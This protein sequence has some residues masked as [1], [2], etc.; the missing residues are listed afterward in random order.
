MQHR[1]V[2]PRRARTRHWAG[3]AVLAAVTAAFAMG[4]AAPTPALARVTGPAAATAGAQF[5]ASRHQAAQIR[6]DLPV[7]IIS[8]NDNS[9]CAGVGSS[10]GTPVIMSNCPAQG[11]TLMPSGA[12]MADGECMGTAPAGL[13]DRH[14][15]RLMPCDHGADQKWDRDLAMLVNRASGQCLDDPQWNTADGTPL[16]TYVCDGRANQTWV[17]P[18][19]AR[20][21]R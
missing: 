9:K 10:V 19:L 4:A 17:V 5:A 7:P 1:K 6:G 14:L 8:G 15:V 21:H 11:W 16:I 20:V 12:I 3:P 18:I 13:P 2:M